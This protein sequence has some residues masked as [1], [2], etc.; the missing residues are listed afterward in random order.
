MRVH[1]KLSPDCL[2]HA[3]SKVTD[4]VFIE[5]CHGDPSVRCHVD[6]SLLGEGLGLLG[7]QTGEAENDWS[8]HFSLNVITG[9]VPEHAD[10]AFDVTPVTG[11]F[12]LVGEL[13]I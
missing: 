4:I 8:V 2:I 13:I 11:S 3:L 7:F 12:K 5:S 6:V 9:D 1:L 10:L